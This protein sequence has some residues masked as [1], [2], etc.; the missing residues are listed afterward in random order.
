MSALRTVAICAALA[1]TV[2]G[3]GAGP[4]VARGVLK[5]RTTIEATDFNAEV[6]QTL[7]AWRAGGEVSSAYVPMACGGVEP[8]L[9]TIRQL[10]SGNQYGRLNGAA[11]TGATASGAYQYTNGTWNNF[12]GYKRAMDAPPAVQDE[13]ARAD[14]ERFLATHDGDVSVIPLL[15]YLGH[16]PTTAELHSVPWAS[17]GN[18]LTPAEY[19]TKWLAMYESKTEECG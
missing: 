12:G 1:G 10:E 18:T 4:A 7:Q 11:E 3:L 15:W 8:I 19:Q 13:K 6:E 16:I 2:V 14:V 5:V 17:Q 9:A